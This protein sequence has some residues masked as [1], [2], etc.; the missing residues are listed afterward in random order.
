MKIVLVSNKLTPHQIPLCNAFNKGHQ[1]YFIETKKENYSEIGW[2]ANSSNYSYVIPYSENRDINVKIKQIIM[3]ADAVIIGSAPDSYVIERLKAGKITFK[4]AE[5][6]YKDGLNIKKFFRALIGTWIHHG[7]FQKY[8]IYML[9][10]SAYTPCDCARFHNYK[11]RM[12]KWGYFPET[13]KYNINELM[14]RKEQF[15]SILWVGRFV[16]WKHPDISV[17]LA[18][19]LKKEGYKFELNIIGYGELEEDLKKLIHN[20]E[21]EDCVYILGKKSPNEV[22]AYMEKSNILL[23]TS[24]FHEG[25]GAVLNEAMNSACVPVV[26]HAVGSAAFLISHGNNGFVYKNGNFEQLCS[27]VKFLLN[28]PEKRMEMGKNAYH[29]ICDMWCAENAAQRF[30][31]LVDYLNRCQDKNYYQDGPCSVAEVILEEDMY[32]SIVNN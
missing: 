29:T 6:F 25:W 13:K 20:L 3:D 2:Y 7:R 22:R 17:H 12:Y 27:E 23:L 10:A 4:Y 26:N 18:S 15:F 21:V 24:D 8:P 16:N 28:N 19:Q 1:F 5:R 31:H 9:C 32:S 11:D 14:K 30:I